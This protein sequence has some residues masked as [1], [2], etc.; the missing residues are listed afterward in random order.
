MNSRI[1]KPT[2]GHRDRAVRVLAGD[3][4][5]MR[6]ARPEEVEKENV[7]TYEWA[8]VEGEGED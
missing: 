2:P 3:H 7:E 6:T 1:P 4:R 5:S 8:G